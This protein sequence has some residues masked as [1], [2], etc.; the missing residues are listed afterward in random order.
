MQ[1]FLRMKFAYRYRRRFI[2]FI[3]Y[4]GFIAM[5]SSNVER[6]NYLWEGLKAV[7]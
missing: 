2:D 7:E 5:R 4:F 3:V 6:L 1:S